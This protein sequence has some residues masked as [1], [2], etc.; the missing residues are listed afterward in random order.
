[1]LSN[2]VFG[3]DTDALTSGSQ[4]NVPVLKFHGL[5]GLR[6]IGSVPFDMDSITNFELTLVDLRYSHTQ[7][8]V[9]MRHDADG[10]FVCGRFFNGGDYARRRAR[11]YYEFF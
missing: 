5:D 6:E 2:V 1:M 11:L 8:T 9:I 10:F 4:I 7:M 3:L